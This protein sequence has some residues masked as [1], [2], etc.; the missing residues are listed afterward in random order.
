MQAL[1]NGSLY[2]FGT[3][4][5]N[6]QCEVII[7]NNQRTAEEVSFITNGK[8]GKLV[9]DC[10]QLLPSVVAHKPT[11]PR[12]SSPPTECIEEQQYIHVNLYDGTL[13]IYRKKET[14]IIRIEDIVDLKRNSRNRVHLTL[15]SMNT[16]PLCYQFQGHL[17][18]DTFQQYVEFWQDSGSV[19]QKAFDMIDQTKSGVISPQRLKEV[20]CQQDVVSLLNNAGSSNAPNSLIESTQCVVEKMLTLQAPAG[21]RDDGSEFDFEDFFHLFLDIPMF[22]LFSCLSEWMNQSLDK[23][24]T[25]ETSLPPPPVLSDPPMTPPPLDLSLLSGETIANVIHNVKW[26]IGATASSIASTHQTLSSKRNLNGKQ[27]ITSLYPKEGVFTVP[28]MFGALVIT[29][30]R[31]IL[32]ARNQDDRKFN[33]YGLP[34]YFNRM[35]I[36]LSTMAQI[37]LNPTTN[38]SFGVKPNIY[39]QSGFQLQTKDLRSILVVLLKQQRNAAETIVH[40]LHKMC[41]SGIRAHLFA[42][43]YSRKFA[44]DAWNLSDIRL[45]YQR[46]GLDTNPDWQIFDNSSFELSDSYPPYLV[47]PSCMS[48]KNIFEAAKHRSRE[49]LPVVTYRDMESGSCLLRSAQPLVGITQHKS[50]NDEILLN[51]CRLSGS[52]L[53]STEASELPEPTSLSNSEDNSDELSSPVRNGISTNGSSNS[54]NFY[55]LDARGK[56]AATV[57]SVMGKGTEDVS[58]YPSTDLEFCNIDNIHVMRSSHASLQ[59]I[60]LP[61]ILGGE[62]DVSYYSKLCESGWLKHTRQ[63]LIASVNAAEKIRIS[64]SS[65]LVHCSD[66]WDRTGQMCFLTQLMLDP[67]YRTLKGFCLLV[68]KEFCS[69]GYKFQDRCGHAEPMN[70][71]ADERSPVFVQGLDASYQIIRQFPR[72]FEFTPELLVFIADHVH[73]GLFGNFL[74]NS[75][76][77]RLEQLNVRRATQ[78]IW[79]YVFENNSQFLQ[80]DYEPH[81]GPIWPHTSMK[82][83]HLWE[84]FYCRWNVNSH[85]VCPSTRTADDC[86]IWQDDWG[87][88][89]LGK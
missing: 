84:R 63:L 10:T 68:E 29:N 59:E 34:A 2:F 66:G 72:H 35:D 75:E 51:A 73:S 12:P 49:R 47:L 48:I 69:F 81:N 5:Q 88:G 62:S 24:T 33:R 53:P 77:Q 44:V 56:M 31:V 16:R 71:L 38:G 3:S 30:Y 58:R 61:S 19:I 82:Q 18:A 45:D 22:S 50:V 57:N 79:S 26:Y 55:I 9:F 36:P 6:D 15:G 23:I 25:T 52:I 14:R 37:T 7:P 41:F 13:D 11:S 87:D 39:H 32:L 42:Y 76:K 46:M 27:N 20:M 43:Q 40:M 21:R 80:C 8:R 85:P 60:V 86:G 28:S 83:I 4:S 64:K 67:Y 70:S 65:V 1:V 17:L 89:K 54:R 78:S 74:G